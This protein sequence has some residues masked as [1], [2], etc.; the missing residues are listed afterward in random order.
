MKPTSTQALQAN[1][2]AYVKSVRDANAKA[3]KTFQEAFAKNPTWTLE[4]RTEDVL[5][6][7][8]Q[9]RLVDWIESIVIPYSPE[10]D[11]EKIISLVN[12]EIQSRLAE[13]VR[14]PVDPNSTSPMANLNTI[15]EG[16]AKAA[17]VRGIAGLIGNIPLSM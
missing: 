1:T 9:L 8:A 17:Y 14:C 11:V 15:C 10:T 2:A 7:Q 3:V 5:V 13:M 12:D 4:W 6:T 16:K